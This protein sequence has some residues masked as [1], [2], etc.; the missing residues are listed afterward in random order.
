VK[1]QPTFGHSS[2]HTVPKRSKRKDC[3]PWNY[4]MNLAD[5]ECPILFIILK[6]IVNIL[7]FPK[8]PTYTIEILLKNS[9]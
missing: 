1:W 9:F 2:S 5:T 3:N 7:G 8:E 6:T 4:I